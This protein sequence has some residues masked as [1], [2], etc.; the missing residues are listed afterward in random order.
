MGRS[1]GLEGRLGARLAVVAGRGPGAS[2]VLVGTMVEDAAHVVFLAE[3]PEEE[4][5]GEQGAPRE[6]D[7]SWMAE[8]AKQVLRLLPGGLTVLGFFLAQPD[9][10]LVA[11][12][13]K[14]RKLLRS[15]AG[16]DPSVPAELLVL[17]SALSGKV[18]DSK[19]ASFRPVEV[20]T[21]G[22]P[23]RYRRLE[24]QLVLDIPVALESDS[25]PLGEDVK[26]VMAK[27]GRMLDT[28]MFI[29]GNKVLNDE[30]VIG[31]PVVVE[32]RKGKGKAAK[33]EAVEE[34]EEP[35]EQEVMT[36][37]LLA[38]EPPL[39]DVVVEE[40]TRARMKLAGKLSCRAYLPPGAR[41]AW[42]R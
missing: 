10:F 22:R 12:D 19:T 9:S 33:V 28:A 3:T 37:E 7:V 21:A 14:L 38:T 40:G 39:E 34:D 8:H 32:G 2:G 18:L 35:E 25:E 24:S 23:V 1:V 27:F 13:G 4:E 17:Q 15:T 42:A 6:L 20:R 11:N 30:A 26:P 41:V 31:K 5:E 36:V 16:L 29:F